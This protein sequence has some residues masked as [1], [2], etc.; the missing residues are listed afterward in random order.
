M[1]DMVLGCA[2]VLLAFAGARWLSGR[3]GHPPWASPV[4]VTALAM[5]AALTLAR[6]PLARFDAATQPLRWLL[7]PAL[8]ALALVIDAN[9]DRVRAQALPV[10]AAVVGG[11]LV[12]LGSAVAMARLAGI[13]GILRLAL[14]TKT[15]TTPFT[16]AIMTRVGGP[17]ALAA[18]LS[19]VTGVVG[20]LLV[21][22]L[23]RALGMTGAGPALGLGVSSHIVGTDWLTRRDSAA[24]GLAALAFVLAGLLMAVV[25]PVLWK[26]V[27]NG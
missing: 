10:L 19:V 1:R 18:A 6:V 22:A 7:G 20:A 15:V 23:F 21:P 16:V 26:W 14:V 12:G 27:G 5:I 24:G 3:L 11:T 9:R 13:D 17:I 4:L 8:V 2:M 25:V